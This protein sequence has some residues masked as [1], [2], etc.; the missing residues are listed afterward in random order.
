MNI[1]QQVIDHELVSAHLGIAKDGVSWD[2]ARKAISGLIQWHVDVALDPKVNGGYALIKVEY[3]LD[4][5][6]EF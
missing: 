4:D 6:Y 2:E 1:W 3:L 5:G